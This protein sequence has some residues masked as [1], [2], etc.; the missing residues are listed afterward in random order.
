MKVTVNFLGLLKSYIRTE[1]VTL[2][3]PD[4]AVFQDLLKEIGRRYNENLPETLWDKTSQAFSLNI[5]CIG[6][7]RDLED[8]QMPLKPGETISVLIHMAGG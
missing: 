7:G 2:E 1:E 8:R 4:G 6:E 3:L 5:L